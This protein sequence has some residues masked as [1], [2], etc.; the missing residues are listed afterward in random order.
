MQDRRHVVYLT[1][2]LTRSSFTGIA[3]KHA[4]YLSQ[5]TKVQLLDVTNVGLAKLKG[6]ITVYHPIAYG[7]IGE[8]PHFWD[9]LLDCM[10]HAY[11]FA[12]KLVGFDVADTDRISDA[13]VDCINEF[14]SHVIVPTNYSRHVYRKCGVKAK[15]HVLPHGIN[16]ANCNVKIQ[17]DKLHDTLKKLIS[18]R[19]KG[20]KYVLYFLWHSPIRKGLDLVIDAMCKVQ[21]ENPKIILVT[22]TNWFPIWKPLRDHGIKHICINAWLDDYNL[23]A[24]YKLVDCLIVP[25]RGGGFELNALEGVAHGTPTIAHDKGCFADYKQY[26]ITCKA[27]KGC[28]PLLSFVLHTGYGFD[29]D[30]DELACK[31]LEVCNNVEYYKQVYKRYALEV[32]VKYNW[33]AI[34]RKLQKLWVRKI[35]K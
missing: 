32:Q 16:P 1:Q 34:G 11:S 29:I 12:D 3:Q 6:S 24:L 9:F 17:W 33:D 22:K 14:F 30:T 19:T 2:L 26:L 5:L 27:K 21:K 7:C 18:L 15:L 25:S 4:H 31:I 8:I 10:L 35:D 20:Y 23:S 13:L 28:K